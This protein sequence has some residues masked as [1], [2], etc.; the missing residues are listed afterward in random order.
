[1]SRWHRVPLLGRVRARSQAHSD[2]AERLDDLESA[3]AENAALAEPLA[4][5]VD[6]LERELMAVVEARLSED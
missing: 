6:G 5:Y 1:M 4:A 3:A 2:L